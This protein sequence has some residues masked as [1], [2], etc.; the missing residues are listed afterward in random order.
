MLLLTLE[1]NG[2]LTAEISEEQIDGEISIGRDPSCQLQA[3]SE[4]KLI[5]SKHAIVKKQGKK[6][7]LQDADSRNGIFFAW[8]AYKLVQVASWGQTNHWG[9]NSVRRGITEIGTRL[10]HS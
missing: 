5:S 8:Q 10:W 1:H 9:D 3:S 7:L 2:Q 4:D 6:L